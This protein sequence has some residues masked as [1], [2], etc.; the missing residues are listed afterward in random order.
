MCVQLPAITTVLGE[1]SL[2]TFL[3]TAWERQPLKLSPGDFTA[4]L[5]GF[6]RSELH[7]IIMHGCLN[8]RDLRIVRNG[9][10]DSDRMI[11]DADEI[12]SPT[13]VMAAYVDGFTIVVNNLQRRCRGISYLTRAIELTL[14]QPLGANAYV[15]P[16]R[17][18]GLAPHFDDHDAFV[19][20]I[21]GE[22]TWQIYHAYQDLPFRGE[23]VDIDK[24][25]LGPAAS[26]F[27]LRAGDMLYIPRG[28]IH[29]AETDGRSSMHLTL[30]VSVP[31]ADL[32][33]LL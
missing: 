26:T 25:N 5:D 12:A 9:A 22:K 6:D 30:G 17:A 10:T 3:E 11:F 31:R 20:Q 27:R 19:L 16:A 21:D 24:T 23:Q 14:R 4:A 33:R 2:D 28:V 7:R 1:M 32:L 8:R 18:R 13:A 29:Q 15:T